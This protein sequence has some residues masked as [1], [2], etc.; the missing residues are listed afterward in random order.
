MS[1]KIKNFM[2]SL[3]MYAA[4]YVLFRFELTRMLLNYVFLV[5][6][7]VY[8]MLKLMDIFLLLNLQKF[9]DVNNSFIQ[10]RI[11][12][13]NEYVFDVEKDVTK[14]IFEDGKMFF[15]F[16]IVLYF[17]EAL[18]YREFFNFAEIII[19]GIISFSLIKMLFVFIY[20]EIPEFLKTFK[21]IGIIVERSEK[22]KAENIHLMTIIKYLI[23]IVLFI[24]LIFEMIN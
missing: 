4:F 1:I 8:I 24:L 20:D 19:L 7:A 22:I 2:F 17:L 3:I 10:T 15:S 13:I 16:G 11:S 9:S 12:N 14:S 18:V 6:M 21:F 23:C 5:F